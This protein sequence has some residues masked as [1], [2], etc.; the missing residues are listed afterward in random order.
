MRL[1]CAS[2]TDNSELGPHKHVC[3]NFHTGHK[4]GQQH[5]KQI[6]DSSRFIEHMNSAGCGALNDFWH[7]TTA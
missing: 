7:N 4:S 6:R 1:T 3:H 2:I 5:T